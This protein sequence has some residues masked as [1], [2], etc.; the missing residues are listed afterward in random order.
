M[1]ADAELANDHLLATI[2]E[3]WPLS[4]TNPEAITEMAHWLDGHTKPAG[5]G[6]STTP[7]LNGNALKRRVTV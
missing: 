2:P 4:K 1:F 7:P 5:N 3:I 6:H